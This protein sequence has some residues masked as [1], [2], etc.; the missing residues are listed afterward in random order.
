MIPF[1]PLYI[2]CNYF[3]L[4]KIFFSNEKLLKNNIIT[5]SVRTSIYTFLKIKNYPPNSKILITSINI[6]SIVEIIKSN[7][8]QII[9]IDLDIDTLDMNK[10]DLIK[11]IKKY[12]DIKCC[13]YSHL[14][15]KINDINWIIDICKNLNIDFIE[16]CAE[17][18]TTKYNGNPNSDMICFSFGSIKKCTCFGGSKTIIKKS[19]D[20]KN[21]KNEIKKYKYQNNYSYIVKLFKYLLISPILNNKYLNIFIRKIFILFNI[22]I[23]YYFNLI[24]NINSNNL[25]ENIKFQQCNLL[26]KYI[27][28]RTNNYVD[29]HIINQTYILNNLITNE[30]IIPGINANKFNNYW[31]YPL[32]CKNKK[33]VLKNIGKKDI[34]YENKISQLI[35][36]DKKCINSQ[37]L[38]DNIILLPI[39]YLISIKNTKYIV[40]KLNNIAIK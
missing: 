16:D 30:Y 10:S 2:D 12:N 9:P 27:L 33:N 34:N 13:I 4:L 21:F 5:Y 18:Y 40:D 11:K 28:Y 29:K 25:I 8:L 38:M 37:K 24:R 6:P 14:F 39:H 20:L 7:N 35:C 15:G 1:F 31:L 22:N 23:N 19:D 32:Y 17:C 26:T 36:L 3:S